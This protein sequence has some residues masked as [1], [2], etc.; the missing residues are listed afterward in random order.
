MNVIALSL[1]SPSKVT[2]SLVLDIFGAVCFIPGGH[3]TVLESINYLCDRSFSQSRFE[4]VV[5]AL[6]ESC[7]ETRPEDKELQVAS[8]SFINSIICGGP[9]KDRA[10]RMHIRFEFISSGLLKII[11]K[12]TM[13]DNNILQNQIDL[14]LLRMENDE[15][16][17]YEKLNLSEMDMESVND[18]ANMLCKTYENTSCQSSFLAILKHLSILPVSSL[19]R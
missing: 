4:V 2:R 12:I 18:V 14:F 8:M 15:S 10:F 19:E 16:E 6:S 11:D 17:A 1:R 9:G 7:N 5:N 13:V 3:A